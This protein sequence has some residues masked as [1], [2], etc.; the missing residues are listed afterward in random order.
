M[1]DHKMME[2]QYK[3]LIAQLSLV[4]LHDEDP[5]C[6]CTFSG[7]KLNEYCIPKHMLTIA[8][9]ASETASMTDS[10]SEQ[11]TLLDIQEKA[12]EYHEKAKKG[13]I[14]KSAAFP[15]GIAEWA[16]GARK[17][18]E[19][20]YYA[21]GV[22]GRTP[23]RHHVSDPGH[24][25]TAEN[26]A[27]HIKFEPNREKVVA[28]Y[29]NPERE[30]LAV[31]TVST[32]GRSSAPL[33]VEKIVRE[34]KGMG[35]SGIILAHNHPSGSIDVSQDD[36]EATVALG[37]AAKREGIELVDH[38]VVGGQ[39]H[40]SF[41]AKGLKVAEHK[42]T[43][44]ERHLASGLRTPE[45]K[46]AAAIMCTVEKAVNTHGSEAAHALVLKG[47]IRAKG[48]PITNTEFASAVKVMAHYQTIPRHGEAELLREPN[49]AQKWVRYIREGEPAPPEG[50]HAT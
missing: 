1:T 8:A 18:L 44:L 6:P 27:Q 45:G 19:P 10:A 9:L 3:E 50:S 49:C 25:L 31:K 36:R 29:T 22:S 16:R 33:P 42:F 28:A 48:Q 4:Q 26:L 38:V 43:K 21:C 2:Y 39:H 14:C 12:Q 13:I 11:K 30:V 17:K 20:I 5:K 7:G 34:A 23:A 40:S 32:G 41:K 37:Q 47:S 35:A 15:S 46:H 24:P